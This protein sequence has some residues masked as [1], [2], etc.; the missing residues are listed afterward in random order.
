VA[1]N[2]K[3]NVKSK[4][5]GK[6]IGIGII[7]IIVTVIGLLAL[8]GGLDLNVTKT[9]LNTNDGSPVLG[10]QSASVTI[11]EFGDYQCP[12]CRKWNIETK[13]LIEK[14]YLQT[15]KA[16][17]IYMDLPII[18]A[19]SFK[20][21]TSS[22]CADEQG[23][24]W[25]YH[26]YLYSNQGH[27][28]DGWAREEKLKILASIFE[29]LDLEKFNK[30]LDSSK[31]DSRVMNNKN[32]GMRIGVSSTPTFIVIGP[33]KSATQI[34]GAQPFSVFQKVIDEKIAS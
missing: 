14:N 12:F 26:D 28:N 15:G 7:G 25:K 34:S 32:I 10:S 13:P 20:A 5:K 22:Y 30:C 4:P 18:G 31:Y 2:K 23:L 3:S 21:H 8:N 16:K 17:M 6:F 24:Y 11:I 33:D 29:E 9:A 1:K 27:E 19:D